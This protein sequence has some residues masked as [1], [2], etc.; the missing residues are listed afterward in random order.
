MPGG[1]LGEDLTAGVFAVAKDE[2]EDRSILNR[3]PRNAHE[4]RV[5]GVTPSFPHGTLFEDIELLPG[6]ELAEGRERNA[7]I[8]HLVL[9]R[10]GRQRQREAAVGVGVSQRSVGDFDVPIFT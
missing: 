6:E 3:A 2:H 4:K 1:P 5:D 10:Q 9:A 8:L 7:G